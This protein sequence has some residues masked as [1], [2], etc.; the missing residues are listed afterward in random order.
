MKISEMNKAELLEY[1]KM[2]REIQNYDSEYPSWQRAFHLARM[3]GLESVEHGCQKCIKSVIE[4]L[5]R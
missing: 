1:M 4:W 3:N 5:E 2:T